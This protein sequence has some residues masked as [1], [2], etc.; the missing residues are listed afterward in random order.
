MTEV[1]ALYGRL[2]PGW[3]RVVC[4][5]RDTLRWEVGV[6]GWAR[7]LR[8]QRA[9]RVDWGLSSTGIIT[10]AISHGSLQNSSLLTLKIFVHY[11]GVTLN[12]GIEYMRGRKNLRLTYVA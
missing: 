3:L 4:A 11:N 8:A 12:G 9:V 6:A 1:R 2:S 7:S 10:Q 5:W